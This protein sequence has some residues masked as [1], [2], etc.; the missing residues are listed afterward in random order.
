MAGCS[1]IKADGGRCKAQAI[2]D[3][4]WCFNHHPDFEEQRRQ[5]GSRGGRRGGRGRPQ[6]ELSDIKAR[7][8]DLVDDVLEG[9]VEKGRAAVASQVLNTY[10]RAVAVELRAVEQLELIARL[11]ELETTLEAKKRSRTWGLKNTGG[12]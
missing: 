5:R 4:Q 9:N 3:S 2:A 7:L 1:G 12:P 11:E 8:A 10:I 6:A